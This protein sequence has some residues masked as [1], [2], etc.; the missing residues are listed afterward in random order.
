MFV[1]FLLLLE[2]S[3][4]T[5]E[6]W[7]FFYVAV[8]SSGTAWK[9]FIVCT[10]NCDVKCV[11]VFYLNGPSFRSTRQDDFFILHES[12]YDS[13]LESTFKTEFLSLLSK[14]YEEMTKRKL[15]ISFADRYQNRHTLDCIC[16][17][18]LCKLP[19]CFISCQARVQ[20]EEGGLGWRGFQSGGVS[21]GPRGPGPA[22]TWR[23]DPQRHSWGR[24]TQVF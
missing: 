6:T 14:R 19:R 13:L 9:I 4:L 12:Q 10:N 1:F 7:R 22:Q 3:A 23:E 8:L 21:E 18:T 16:I 24:S 15:T 2:L 17:E 11:L 20:S 5:S